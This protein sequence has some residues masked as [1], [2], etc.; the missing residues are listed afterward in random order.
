MPHRI[1]VVDDDEA[2][3]TG[4]RA[5]LTAWGYDT[6]AAAD[7][8]DALEKAVAHPPA[9][10]ISDLMMPKLDGLGLLAALKREYPAAA[11]IILT[12]HASIESAVQATKEGAYDYLTKPLDPARLQLLVGKALERHGT[13]RELHALRRQ[14]RQ[15]GA[16]GRLV[17]SSRAM[18][19]IMRQL[20]QAG[21]TDAT[22][23]VT[24]ESGTGKELVARTVHELSPRASAPFV[25]INCAAIP[26]SLL[27]SEIFGHEKG[28]FTGAQERRTGCFELAHGGTLFLDEVAEMDPAVQ[29]KFLRVLQE[30][31]LRRVGGRNEIRVDVRIVAATN[32]DPIKA[33]EAGA[34]R[35]DLYY[36]LNVFQIALPPLRDRMDDIPDLIQAVLEDLNERHGRSVR[37]LS[38][39]AMAL[40]RQHAWPG[41]VRELRNAIERAVIVCAGDLIE[42]D[43]LSALRPQGAVAT[44]PAAADGVL[45]PV[46]TTID[47]G[48]RQLILKTLA[49][50]DNNK[51]R[52]AEV[53][54][55]SLKTLHNKLAKY[56]A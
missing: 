41:N 46:G 2:S 37:G 19:D 51:T 54:G 52:A 43:H 7:G 28:A 56:R 34:L 42:V 23:L 53:L 29:A 5:L 44:T 8:A 30:G 16:F 18:Q 33:I 11:V 49:H 35:E 26:E 45:L 32:Q 10:V 50:T 47:D 1:L 48:E 13:V 38:E 24:G 12:A 4:L 3:R 22:V 25:A 55:I 9:V 15:R 40:L 31:R 27:E 21:P 20:E 14:L 36:R 17:G 6:I 39:A